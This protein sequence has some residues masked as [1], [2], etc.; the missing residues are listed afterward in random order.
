MQHT[1]RPWTT[2]GV[3]LVCASL[4]TV[5]PE[6]PQLPDLQHLSV[7]LTTVE[8]GD[9]PFPEVSWND[10][11]ANTTANWNGLMDMFNHTTALWSLPQAVY[12][13]GLPQVLTDLST[14]LQALAKYAAE[15][16][17]Y[18]AA[19]AAQMGALDPTGTLPPIPT[20]PNLYGDPVL[21]PVSALSLLLQNAI[22]SGFGANAARV[23]WEG[24]YQNMLPSI[25]DITT[26]FNNIFTQFGNLVTGGSFSTSAVNTD[27][28]T[29]GTDLTNI[30]NDL[31]LAPT[32]ILNDYLN[33]YPVVSTAPDPLAGTI[34]SIGGAYTLNA[35][36]NASDNVGTTPEFGLL[37]NP[38]AAITVDTSGFGDGTATSFDGTAP[39]DTG[40]LAS[41]LQTMQTLSDELLTTTSTIAGSGV[42]AP[43]P[44]GPLTILGPDTLTFNLDLSNIPVIGNVIDT[45]NNTVIPA[46]DGTLTKAID[47][48][49]NGIDSLNNTI[50]PAVNGVIGFYNGCIGNPACDGALNVFATLIGQ[51]APGTVNTISSTL[52]PTIPLSDIPSIPTIPTLVGNTFNLPG[53]A[54]P[55]V[56][57]YVWDIA[58]NEMAVLDSIAGVAAPVTGTVSSDAIGNFLADNPVMNLGTTFDSLMAGI[59]SDT[60]LAFSATLPLDW[61]N[62]V[63]E[64]L[65]ALFTA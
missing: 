38:D 28:T 32:T 53:T 43:D 35:P 6:S 7:R 49:N 65:N 26:Q 18:N 33:G 2:T 62:L 37:T 17:A 61:T 59:F 54:D 9:A 25:N 48:V 11:V 8:H 15:L 55:G 23:G 10:L 19:V 16:S 47:G 5:T 4:I 3:A 24:V 1:L 34:S 41:L 58:Q 29:I 27:F 56:S 31:S 39:L 63:A 40:T 36:Y 52:I 20:M 12:T 44:T 51:S 60:P 13:Q 50:A 45:I 21:N 14:E 30:G 22:S 64:S 46:L 42:T 57:A